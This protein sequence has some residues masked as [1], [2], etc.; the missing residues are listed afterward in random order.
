MTP[1]ARVAAAIELLDAIDA[2]RTRPADALIAGWFRRRRY[3]GG[4]DR[5]AIQATVYTVLRRRAQI[6]WWLDGAGHPVDSRGR[7]IIAL[8]LGEEWRAADLDAAFDGG[9]YRPARLDENER[10]LATALA[11]KGFDD[12]AQPAHVRGNI[13]DWMEEAFGSSLGDSL[14]AELAALMCEATVDLR[15]NRLKTTRDTVAGMLAAQGI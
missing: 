12:P 13:P 1:G 10:G 11:G 4:G 9:Q 5:R 8:V 15:I 7:V 14:E 6:D 2:D 3:A